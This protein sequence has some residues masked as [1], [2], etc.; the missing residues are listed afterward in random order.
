MF[1]H[2]AFDTFSFLTPQQTGNPQQKE[3]KEK[4]VIVSGCSR[5]GKGRIFGKSKIK[6]RTLDFDDVYFCKNDVAERKNKTLIEAA[7][8][9]LVNSKLPTTFWA[10]AVNTACYVLNRALVIKPHNKTPYELIH[11]RH[12]LIDFMKPF[13]CPKDRAVDAGKK[14]TEVDANQVSDNGGHDDQVTRSECEG[15]LQQERKTEHINGTNSFNTV[16]SPVNTAG[17]SFVN[18]SSPSSIMLLELLLV[19]MHLRTSF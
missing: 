18:A 15:L 5:D 10:E 11:G 8:T 16:S 13:G 4:G 1:I 17:P 7:I 3:Y 12:P 19:L 9:M 2:F 6:T 14:D